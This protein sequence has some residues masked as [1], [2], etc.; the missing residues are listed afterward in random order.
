M[1]QSIF[2]LHTDALN[3]PL[4][5]MDLRLL[6]WLR[7]FTRSKIIAACGCSIGELRVSLSGILKFEFNNSSNCLI[8]VKFASSF[9]SKKMLLAMMF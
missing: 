7:V 8:A 9:F 6:F 3:E 1:V 4:K 2:S 5:F